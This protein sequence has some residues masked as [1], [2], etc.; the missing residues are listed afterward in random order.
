MNTGVPTP[1]GQVMAIIRATLERNRAG[2]QVQWDVLGHHKLN[3]LRQLSFNE[4]DLRVTLRA[5]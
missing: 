1:P 5:N 4:D 2:T 3:R